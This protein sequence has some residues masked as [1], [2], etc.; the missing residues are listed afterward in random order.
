M[1]IN[2]DVF[3]SKNELLY[4]FHIFSSYLILSTVLASTLIFVYYVLADIVRLGLTTKCCYIAL[5]V[6][7]GDYEAL[8]MYE[9]LT[10]L[11]RSM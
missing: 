9:E 2:K 3:F 8:R 10:D 5:D 11:L 6:L 7:V 1:K 4:Y